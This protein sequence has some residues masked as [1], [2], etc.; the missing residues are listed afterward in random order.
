V[1]DRKHDTFWFVTPDE[2][3]DA[4]KYQP[5]AEEVERI[6]DRVPEHVGEAIFAVMP[7]DS[8]V[9]DPGIGYRLFKRGYLQNW[10]V[11]WF[12]RQLED[13]N[14]K[15]P[16]VTNLFKAFHLIEAYREKKMFG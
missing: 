14:P 3:S 5:T 4:K 11:L 16:A 6:T 8:L 2:F 15:S 10:I 1:E 13:R 7:A 9:G 12:V